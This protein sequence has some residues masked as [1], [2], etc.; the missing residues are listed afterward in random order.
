[1][2]KVSQQTPWRLLRLLRRKVE[3]NGLGRGRVLFR[4]T[5]G[6]RPRAGHRVT[7]KHSSLQRILTQ[8]HQ[9]LKTSLPLGSLLLHRLSV[10]GS[11]RRIGN[12]SKTS[13][14][15]SRPSIVIWSM[16]SHRPSQPSGRALVWRTGQLLV[17]ARSPPWRGVCRV[18]PGGRRGRPRSEQIARQATAPGLASGGGGQQR[19]DCFR[20]SDGNYELMGFID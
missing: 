13:D 12:G 17:S 20:A 7:C 2:R 5:D 1:M 6:K 4:C 19:R 11:R 9:T 10:C 14:R 18:A 16:A 8:T 15:V 3:Q